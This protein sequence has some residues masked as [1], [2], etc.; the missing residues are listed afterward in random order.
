MSLSR[1][2]KSQWSEFCRL[3]NA[4]LPG[5]RA[6]IEVASLELGVQTAVRWLTVIGVTYDARMDAMELSLDGVDHLI[7]HPTEVYME[8]GSGGVES[9]AI[10]ERDVWQIVTLRA[11]LMLPRPAAAV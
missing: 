6:E 3:L 8:S 5:Q 11:P 10:V 7:F 1:I 4:Q 9:L 2:E